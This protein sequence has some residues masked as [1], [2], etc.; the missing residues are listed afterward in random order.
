MYGLTDSGFNA[1]RLETIKGEIEQSLRDRIAQNIDLRPESIFGQFVGLESE[2]ASIFWELLQDVYLSQYPDYATGFSLDN[3]VSINLIS[4]LEAQKTNVNA[5]CYGLNNTLLEAG[6]EAKN[7]LTDEVYR[8][9]TNTT[10]SRT[11]AVECVFGVA[12][13]AVGTYTITVGALTY[14][15][16][17]LIT[18]TAQNILQGIFDAMALAPLT[19]IIGDGI[20][21]VKTTT[22]TSFDKTANL[23]FVEVGTVVYF[24]AIESGAKMLPIG[25]LDTIETPV[26]GWNRISNLVDGVAGRA[27][28]SDEDLRIRREQSILLLAQH[29]I[30]AIKASIRTI[31][32]VKD[33]FAMDNPN[34]IT[35]TFGTPRQHIWVIVEGGDDDEIAKVIFNKIAGGIGMRG[36]EVVIVTDDDLQQFEINF[37]R[38]DYIDVLIEI[39]YVRLSNFPA[40]GEDL[41]KEALVNRGDAFKINEDLIYSRLY[42]P[43]NTVQGVQVDSLLVDGFMANIITAPNEKIRILESNITLIDVTV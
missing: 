38:P 19:R 32:G 11:N 18:D 37:D 39:E 30:P 3:A 21:T 23:N 10:I 24:E 13:V 42:T 36:D 12:S 2:M 29:T 33:V 14:S 27:L 26:F 40:N 25:A 35:D 4:R 17:A 34:E 6:R 41:I 15:Y 43:I 5:V 31:S 8:S 7:S 20:L 1:K 28:E 9:T 22:N 16:T